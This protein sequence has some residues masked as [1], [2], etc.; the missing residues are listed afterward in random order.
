[1]RLMRNRARRGATS[2]SR[3]AWAERVEGI[4]AGADLPPFRRLWNAPSCA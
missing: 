3:G 2:R 4:N 1:M